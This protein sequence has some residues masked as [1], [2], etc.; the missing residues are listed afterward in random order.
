MIDCY[1][2]ISVRNVG[3][4]RVCNVIVG[5]S[6][7]EFGDAGF[8]DVPPTGRIECE[9]VVSSGAETGIRNG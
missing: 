3:G 7:A 6:R 2:R 1:S 8:A 9:G 5:V 4:G